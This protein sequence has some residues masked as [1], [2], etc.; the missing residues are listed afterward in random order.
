MK[1]EKCNVWNYHRTA[2]K[3]PKDIVKQGYDMVSYAYREDE[4]DT[5]SSA[6]RQYKD[7]V[8][9]LSE[10]LMAGN[11][12][13]DLGCGCG[14]PVA[15]LLAEKF[16]V[17]GVD[18]SC[19]QIERAKKLVPNA[20]FI[21]RDMCELD[22]APE[23]FDAV[24]C[25]YAIIHVPIEEQQELLDKIYHW[26]KAGGYLLLVAGHTLWTG[27][28]SNW[29][30]VEGGDMYWSQAD[31]DTYVRWLESAGFRMLWDRFIPEDD[32]G[33]TLIFAKSN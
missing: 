10:Q 28:E 26:L 24:I 7:W 19:V 13:L 17:T 21:C 23:S 14:V 6:Y 12:V 1:S 8:D 31:R 30:G 15:K 25:L 5:D 4:P 11:S 29:L 32:S 22:F 16:N 20:A 27:Q 18:I 2:M 33:H 3:N 9:E